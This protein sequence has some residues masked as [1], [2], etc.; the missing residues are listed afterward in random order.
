[1][2]GFI[3]YYIKYRKSN[4]VFK[5]YLISMT[6]ICPIYYHH[7]FTKPMTLLKQFQTFAGTG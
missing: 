7:W 6:V 3:F 2:N 1:M 5:T 4:Y